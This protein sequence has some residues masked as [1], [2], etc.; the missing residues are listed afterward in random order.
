MRDLVLTLGQPW[1]VV[2]DDLIWNLH[3]ALWR[4]WDN[5]QKDDCKNGFPLLF[6][7][8]SNKPC[9]KVFA[10]PPK[11][12]YYLGSGFAFSCHLTTADSCFVLSYE[13]CLKSWADVC[14][15]RLPHRW[16]ILLYT[17]HSSEARQWIQMT[18]A[19]TDQHHHVRL[20]RGSVSG[21]G[22]SQGRKVFE[23]H[24]QEYKAI[25]IACLCWAKL[26]GDSRHE[27]GLVDDFL[28]FFSLRWS[29]LHLQKVT[30]LF[31]TT[32]TLNVSLWP[33]T[34]F[35]NPLS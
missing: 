2:R 8:I 13:N 3:V 22:T 15:Y 33:R 27:T 11:M 24:T 25:L 10:A 23:S 32:Q 6:L 17:N 21:Q 9:T 34:W 28:L 20:R 14:S 12:G 31:T 5:N 7:W 30:V 16:E 26:P 4:L 35:V 1:M 19:D 29:K 18:E